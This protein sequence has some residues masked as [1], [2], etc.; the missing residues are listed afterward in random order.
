MTLTM[1]MLLA[2]FVNSMQ[3]VPI[4]RSFLFIQL[5]AMKCLDSHKKSKVESLGDGFK[6]H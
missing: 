4:P 1:G 2:K 6:F 3:R 5:L